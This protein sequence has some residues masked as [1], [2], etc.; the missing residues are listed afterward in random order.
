MAHHYQ[1]SAQGFG[2]TSKF[3]DII[4]GTELIVKPKPKPK[5]KPTANGKANGKV[6]GKAL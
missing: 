1:D 3:W 6:N 5:A 2:V 4:F